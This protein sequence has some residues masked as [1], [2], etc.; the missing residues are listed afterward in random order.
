MAKTTTAEK[1]GR[2]MEEAF[3]GFERVGDIVPC[4]PA[5]AT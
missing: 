2:S 4:F 3:N 1:G 5:P